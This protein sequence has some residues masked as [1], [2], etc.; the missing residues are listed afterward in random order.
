MLEPKDKSEMTHPDVLAKTEAAVQWCR[1]AS[2]HA[3]TFNGKAWRYALIPH[4]AI[5]ENITLEWLTEQFGKV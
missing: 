5:A 4:D 1:H 2:D 3:A